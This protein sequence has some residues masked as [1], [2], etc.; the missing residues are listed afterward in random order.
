MQ[1]GTFS[2]IEPGSVNDIFNSLTPSKSLL[3]RESFKSSFMQYT[4][5]GALLDM[6]LLGEA[7]SSSIEDSLTKEEW[8]ETYQ[9]PGLTYHDELTEAEA[10]VI[11]D[12]ADRKMRSAMIMNQSDGSLGSTLTILAGTFGSQ[13]TDPSNWIPLGGLFTK[14]A[15]I[16]KMH[17]GVALQTRRGT[18]HTLDSGKTLLDRS[19]WD[20][21][22]ETG[23]RLAITEIGREAVFFTRDQMYNDDYDARQGLLNV[24]LAFG[25]GT[26]MGLAIAKVRAISM[27]KHFTNL[28]RTQDEVWA[29]V[30]GTRVASSN[31]FDSGTTSSS[32]A[33]RRTPLEEADAAAATHRQHA[34]DVPEETNAAAKAAS[35][36]KAK[37][38]NF[39]EKCF[40]RMKGAK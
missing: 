2:Y 12:R 7:A 23:L 34:A 8:E 14:S 6:A 32:T 1:L 10:L 11:T 5:P 18:A 26:G 16:K 36:T 37:V 33:A 35:E 20:V 24:G 27:E 25:I 28:L 22:R 30:N 39:L 4:V 17:G 13:V 38:L 29:D 15:S 31:S 19:V 9:R 3:F 40:A 21:G